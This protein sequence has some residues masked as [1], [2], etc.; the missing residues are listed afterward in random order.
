[1]ARL[2]QLERLSTGALARL[3]RSF[4]YHP[5][6]T[7]LGSV[8]IIVLLIVPRRH[9]R[10]LLA[11]RVRDPGL[12]HPEGDR[13]DRVRSS[14]PSR[15]SVLNVVFAAPEGEH[16][17]TPERKAAIEDGGRQGRRTKFAAPAGRPTEN[18]HPGTGEHRRPVRCRTRLL[19]GRA[20]R[21]RRGAVRADGQGHGPG[22]G[23]GGRGRLSPAV[24]PVG[25]VVEF[26]GERLPADRTGRPS[27]SA[28]SRRSSSCWSCSAPSWR[29]SLS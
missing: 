15:A 3:A 27:C 18:G 10:R 6:R 7:I 13:P 14:S 23:R 26:G 2:P 20:D 24:E 21:L 8:G 22:R 19:A 11:R 17:D 1:M 29:C 5:W 9:H 4:A 16:L 25:V 12:G 28:C